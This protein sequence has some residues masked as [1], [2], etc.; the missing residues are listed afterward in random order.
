VFDG[1][2]SGLII[3]FPPSDWSSVTVLRSI[4]GVASSFFVEFSGR[5]GA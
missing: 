1:R 5:V 3:V 2:L 4:L